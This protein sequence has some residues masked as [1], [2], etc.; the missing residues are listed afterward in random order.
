[1]RKQE[2][3]PVEIAVAAELEEAMKNEMH[4]EEIKEEKQT[5]KERKG[6]FNNLLNTTKRWFEDDDTKD[7]N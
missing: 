7:F 1:N 5:N 2:P 3:E 6:W 4:T